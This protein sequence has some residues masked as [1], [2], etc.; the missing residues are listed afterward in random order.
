M[1]AM[2][3]MALTKKYPELQEIVQ[4]VILIDITAQRLED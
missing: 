1:G 4:R 3:L 2:A